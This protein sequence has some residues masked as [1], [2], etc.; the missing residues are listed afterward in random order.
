MVA[1]MRNLFLADLI[2][3]SVLP[4]GDRQMA[5]EPT[6]ETR[7]QRYDR[8]TKEQFELLG[9]FVQAFELM[10]FEVRRGCIHL[11]TSG[12]DH[13]S[14]MN[15]VFH[16]S[17]LSAQPLFDILSA[18][19]TA[20]VVELSPKIDPDQRTTTLGVLKQLRT[21]FKDLVERRNKLLHGTWFIGWAN[22]AAT[23]FSKTSVM[24]LKWTAEGEL[25]PPP[26]KGADD[27]KQLTSKCADMAHMILSLVMCIHLTG[28]P[29]VCQNFQKQNG[30]W[31]TTIQRVE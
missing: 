17:A 13:Q 25:K 26:L 10:V 8:Q 12:V 11:T 21:N 15:R 1:A 14:L 7:D 3:R 6:E 27:L 19:I 20:I 2:V 16:H 28:G 5:D 30:R 22:P 29:R 4:I 31:I 18:L 9:R 24:N 23:D